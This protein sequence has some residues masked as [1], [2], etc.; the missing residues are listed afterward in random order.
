MRIDFISRLALLVIAGFMI[1]AT[2]VW[3]MSTVEWIFIVGGAV[4]LLLA[5]TGVAHKST[6]QRALDGLLALL[7]AWS[8]VQALV[9]NGTTLEWVSFATAAAAAV[10]ATVGLMLHEMTTERV[11]H[12]LSVTTPQ[13]STSV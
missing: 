11:V 8:I 6:P 7:G 2:Q 9:F 5:A 3:A 10:I 12:E 1:I 13:H 4:M